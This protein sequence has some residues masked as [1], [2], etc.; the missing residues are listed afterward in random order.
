MDI[1]RSNAKLMIAKGQRGHINADTYKRH[2]DSQ[3]H[4]TI[5]ELEEVKVCIKKCLELYYES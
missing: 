4:P 1:A 2:L 3:K 5:S